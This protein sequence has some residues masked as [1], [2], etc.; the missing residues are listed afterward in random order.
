M[1][2]TDIPLDDY[3]RRELERERDKPAYHTSACL[4]ARVQA[5]VD[6]EPD[7]GCICGRSRRP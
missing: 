2:A 6:D 3:N 4:N 1:A 5:Y 7:P